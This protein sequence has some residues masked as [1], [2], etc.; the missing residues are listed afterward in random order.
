MPEAEATVAEHPDDQDGELL[1]HL[2]LFDVLRLTV[3]AFHGGDLDLS[4]PILGVMARGA[5]TPDRGHAVCDYA[6][7]CSGAGA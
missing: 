7:G 5:L 4:E 3:S 2:F 1:L 6:A